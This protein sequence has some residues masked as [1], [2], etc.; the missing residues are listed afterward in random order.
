MLVIALVPASAF[1]DVNLDE[2]G[3]FLDE[4]APNTFYVT[5]KDIEHFS[6]L[7]ALI[8]VEGIKT[9]IIKTNLLTDD[10]SELQHLGE[11]LGAGALIPKI[12]SAANQIAS[13]R[14]IRV[15]PAYNGRFPASFNV[16]ENSGH[17]ILQNY[18]W[19]ANVVYVYDS[20]RNNSVKI[21]HQVVDENGTLML[22]YA[23]DELST[24]AVSDDGQY[25]TVSGINSP[26]AVI[27]TD[28]AFY[29]YKEV[30]RARTS[31]SQGNL[32]SSFSINQSYKYDLT[33][34]FFS[35]IGF[36]QPVAYI[37]QVEITKV[38]PK[39]EPLPGA[40]FKLYVDEGC[41]EEATR[42]DVST[43]ERVPVGE[44]TTGS[45]GKAVIS[46]LTDN[47][48]WAKEIK[49][50][51]G[52]LVNG[53][54]QKL[55]VIGQYGNFVL[56]FAG[57]EGTQVEINKQ[58]TTLVP[59]WTGNAAAA[60]PLELQDS[61]ENKETVSVAQYG[62]DV[63]FRA[64]G[65]AVTFND[66]T[67]AATVDSNALNPATYTLKVGT[68]APQTFNSLSALL[69]YVN[70]KLINGSAT[71]NVDAAD[72]RAMVTVTSSEDVIYIPYASTAASVTVVDEYVP[73][74]FTVNKTWKND[75][76]A[77]RGE[78][79]DV[80]LYQDGEPYGDPVRLTE[81]ENWTYTWRNLPGG[82]T[83]TVDE[84]NVPEDY[85]KEIGKP[86]QE[87]GE[88]LIKITCEITNT[89]TAAPITFDNTTILVI[90]S[91]VMLL[92]VCYLALRIRKTPTK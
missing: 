2:W 38:N 61:A 69:A 40:V 84:P 4:S 81:A 9:I 76:P 15:L 72:A 12:D 63:F 49:A 92:M 24:A 65:K 41:T 91:G 46:G 19:A 45:D 31:D 25:I 64:G 70:D 71:E 21:D 86:V 85:V 78:Y 18:I 34:N 47:V 13:G 80:Q 28:D 79:L 59:S 39:N 53:T 22:Q 54:P 44:V 43:G 5:E 11:S 8:G 83:Y 87:T 17:T 26:D 68:R 7:D 56:K 62:K 60:T 48:Y 35:A 27:G 89:H 51:E 3:S 1:A 75:T 29:E 33:A 16:R 52:Y 67:A 82:H 58:L 32:G 23:D 73:V 55:P 88:T 36:S 30:I 77:Q 6:D 10:L 90:V 66:T 14:P 37:G 42:V 57:G 50:P 20:N 74:E